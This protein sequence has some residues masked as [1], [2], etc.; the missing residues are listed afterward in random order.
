MTSESSVPQ[1]LRVALVHSIL[2]FG[3]TEHYIR[4]LVRRSDPEQIRWT[5]AVPDA[6]ELR[7][8]R[9]LDAE[10]VALSLAS[11]SNAPRA[12]AA[13][14]RV[15]R[16]ASPDVVHVADVDPSAMVA[17]WT[18]ARPV[19]VT[20]HTPELRP[21]YNAVGQALR[22]LAWATRP[23]V[24][25]TSEFDRETGITREPIARERTFVIPLGID[26]E[27][28][29]PRQGDGRLRRELGLG[30][31]VRIVGTVG[32]LK[33]QKRRDLL[34]DTASQVDAA[35]VIAGDGP[36][37]PALEAQIERLG[38]GDRVFLLGH[39]D[40]VPEV[41]ADLDLFALSS[42]FEG[43]CLAVAEAL[44][45]GRPVVA[46]CVGGVPQT[47]ADEQTGLLVPPGDVGELATA[48]RRL[49][50]DPEEARRLA[51]AGGEHVRRLYPLDA[52]V[53]ATVA[54][55]RRLAE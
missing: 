40:D 45:A 23:Q 51:A 20:H 50:D 1:P 37:R 26:L 7:P 25:F 47:V 30:P 5:L 41:L 43:M 42:D 53:A 15:L 8:L 46:T 9:E 35:F 24:I 28:F 55:Y 27:R 33:R 49:L 12:A 10:V 19:V 48:I 14:Q 4:E 34:I 11:Y 44:A 31:D 54:L 2:H 18:L 38:L 32:L 21:A 6:E 22:R 36:E 29:A 16:A 39:R 13:V 3:S 17:G 52:M